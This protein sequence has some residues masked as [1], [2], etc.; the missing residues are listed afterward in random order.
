MQH[1]G[2]GR[3]SAASKRPTLALEESQVA[4]ATRP[5][6]TGALSRMGQSDSRG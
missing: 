1:I 6:E 3:T 2:A 4:V 5:R